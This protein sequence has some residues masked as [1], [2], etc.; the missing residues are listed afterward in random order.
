MA[1][2]AHRK[3]NRIMGTRNGRIALGWLAMAVIATGALLLV[4]S[5]QSGGADP[6]ADSVPAGS[7]SQAASASASRS[8]AGAGS[9]SASGR[10]SQHSPSAAGKSTSPEGG[11]TTRTLG[12]KAKP[13]SC[14]YPDETNTGVPAGT[15]LKAEVSQMT[16]RKSGVYSGLNIRG[17]LVIEAD[18]V[19]V[20]NSRIRCVDGNHGNCV[21]LGERHNTIQDS[22][23]G[24]GASGHDYTAS[25]AAIY[26][27][28]TSNTN[29]ILRVDIHHTD[30]GLRMDGG[31]TLQD[32]YIHALASG[33]NGSHSDG[34][35][36][37]GGSG[38]SFLHNTIWGGN[39]DAVFLQG[40]DCGSNDAS[41]LRD[42]VVNNNL[43]LCLDEPGNGSSYGISVGRALN[44]SI[45]NNHFDRGWQ[46]GPVGIFWD[47]S[48]SSLAGN[49]YDD[50]GKPIP[51]P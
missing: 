23:I 18:N 11:P 9:P 33:V 40:G 3:I 36:S 34:S 30:D 21:Q 8:A 39:N 35:Q 5:G 45:T 25:A 46:A 43:F 38:M 4:R 51:G 37:C 49:V 13:S 28:G 10:S 48:L 17:G 27:G 32:S 1:T 12:C 6:V 20:K 14:G 24:G 22:E 15:K 19:T 7:E 31:T 26:S 29:K 16:I 2:A 50:N 42:V 44:V 47:N 41:P